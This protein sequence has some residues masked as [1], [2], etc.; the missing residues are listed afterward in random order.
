MFIDFF[1]KL[2]SSGIPVSPTSFLTLQKALSKGLVGSV[3]DFYTA[4]RTVL[5]KS[6]RYF[7]LY[8]QIFAH[9][10][11]GAEIPDNDRIDLTEISRAMLEEWLKDPMTLS[12]ALEVDEATFSKLTPE[13]L[14]Q[15][16]IKR[17]Q[18]QKERHDGGNRWI[19]TGG[20]APVGHSGFHPGGMRVGGVSRNRS[21]VKVAMD[22]RYKDYS[23]TGPLTQSMIG[24]ALKRLRNMIPS[25]PEDTVNVDAT[26][27]QTM[28][29]AGEIELVF[30]RSLKNRLKVILAVDNGGWSMDP[31]IPVVQT[32]FDYA[33]S[34]FKDLKTFFFH[35]TIYENIWEDSAR[36][37]KPQKIEAFAHLDPDTRFIVVG[38]ATMAPY[39][40][41]V[42]DGSIHIEERSGKPSVECLKLLIKTFPHSVWLNPTPQRIWDYTQTITIIRKIFPMFE[43]TLDGLEKAIDHLM[44]KN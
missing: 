28:K 29:N 7:D 21:A 34:H 36:M 2:K 41:M 10:F 11:E 27:Y 42:T 8:D 37:K 25:G 23:L 16:F 40:L 4:A 12:Q 20:K 33:R 19:G 17:L 3:D 24:E 35:N 13:E 44:S 18:D 14:I 1:Y 5:I 43:L 39:E 15:Y 9:H 32:L 6:E 38:D 30:D 26:I 31:Y 22:R